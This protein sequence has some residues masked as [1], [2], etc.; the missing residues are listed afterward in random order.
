ME[1]ASSVSSMDP[2]LEIGPSVSGTGLD[3]GVGLS[4]DM[5]PMLR[6]TMSVF[7][8]GVDLGMDMGMVPE[9]T[10]LVSGMGMCTDMTQARA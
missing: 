2:V 10:L 6:T 8:M 3:M 7:G 1:T 9:T 5:G 4:M